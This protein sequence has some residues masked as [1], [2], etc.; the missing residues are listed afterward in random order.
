MNCF[1]QNLN[2]KFF[3]SM[4]LNEPFIP[5]RKGWLYHVKYNENDD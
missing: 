1:N 5:N 2:Y 3:Y 4:K